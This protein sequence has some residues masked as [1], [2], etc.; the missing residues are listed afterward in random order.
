MKQTKQNEHTRQNR[1]VKKKHWLTK[2][3]KR[4]G[5]TT[6]PAVQDTPTILL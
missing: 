5:E 2:F 6:R 1:E 3:T 4:L